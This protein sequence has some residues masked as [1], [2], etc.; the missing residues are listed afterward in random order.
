M[1]HWTEPSLLPLGDRYVLC[2]TSMALLTAVLLLRSRALDQGQQALNIG[3][4]PG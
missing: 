3:A 4:E 1:L 2:K